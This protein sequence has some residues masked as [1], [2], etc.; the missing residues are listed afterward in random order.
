MWKILGAKKVTFL[1]FAYDIRQ[2]DGSVKNMAG[3]LFPTRQVTYRA[4]I[5]H[6]T[7]IWHLFIREKNAGSVITEG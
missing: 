5:R 3:A 4:R 2:N 1:I 6:I 7:I